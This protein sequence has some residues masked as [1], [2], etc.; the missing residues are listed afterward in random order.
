MDVKKAYD[1]WANQYDS[2][3]NKTRDLE[4]NALKATLANHIFINCLEIGC[5]TGK[6]TAWLHSIASN[7]TAID[8]S[9]EML[10]KAKAKIQSDHVHFAIADITKDWDFVSH[11]YDLVT[12]SLMLEHIED[13]GAIFKKLANSVV[14]DGYVYIGELHPFKQYTGS[15]A[16][17][18]TENGLEIV[19]CFNHHI[20]DFTNAATNNGFALVSINEFFDDDDH[21][22]IP[23]ILTLLLQKI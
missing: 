17:F 11:Q 2:N 19:T 10:A 3:E 8:L 9:E 6:N 14:L 4:A 22:Q 13:L 23:R 5:G 18:E 21:G 7:I 15:K 16:R 20:S 1:S 12:F